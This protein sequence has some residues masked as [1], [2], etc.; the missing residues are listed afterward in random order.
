MERY[1]FSPAYPTREYERAAQRVVEYFAPR[2][3]VS[4]VLLTASCARGKA[5][6]DSC[7][8]MVVLLE[9]EAYTAQLSDLQKDWDAFLQVEQAF[10]EL[11]KV[12]AYSN[13]EVDFYDG[14]FFPGDHG[15]TT[16]ADGFELGIG[17]LL[18]Y[19]VLL[20]CN[21]DYYDQLR[22]HWLPYYADDLR[23]ERM[24]MVRH[25]C[26]NNLDHV[27]LY[28]PR[29]LYFQ[30]FQRLW[31]ALGEFLQLLFI[32]R[33]IYPIAY[34]KWVR[35]QVVDILGMPELY[36]ELTALFEIQHFESDELCRKAEVVMRLLE[37]YIPGE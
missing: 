25:F 23:L 21:D 20:H 26:V 2:K 36:P 19:S 14:Q 18:V 15:W 1:L 11:M 6:P 31:H 13:L 10:Q 30:S 8:D 3:E 17:N 29:G 33:R 16:G 27:R 7:L 35:E 28:V 12:G 4:A 9:P 22:N 5:S 24:K 37:D 32:S 34:D